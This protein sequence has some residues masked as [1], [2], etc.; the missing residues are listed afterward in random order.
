MKIAYINENQERLYDNYMLRERLRVNKSR[1]QKLLA[2]Y[3]FTTNDYVTLQ[4]KVLY[5]EESIV[6]FIEHLVIKKYLSEQKRLCNDL[7]RQ[8]K[9]RIKKL[10]SMNEP[11]ENSENQ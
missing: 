7:S 5:T 10:K 2:Q 9:E 8:M 4:N 1:L 6:N 3:N 11:I